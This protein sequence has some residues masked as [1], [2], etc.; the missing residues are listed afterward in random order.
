MKTLLV[1]DDNKDVLSAVKLLMKSKVD[2]V[3]TTPD[4]SS[5]PQLI[6]KHKPQVVLLDMNFRATINSGNE[7]LYWLSEIKRIS[8]EI[9]VVL[10]TAYADVSLAVEGMKIG[11]SDFIVK[12]FDTRYSLKLLSTPSVATKGKRSSLPDL[13]CYGESLQRCSR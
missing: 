7:G 13:R 11:A 12:P 3:V 6:R 8:P 9:A 2:E 1:V 4:P 10:F 5:I